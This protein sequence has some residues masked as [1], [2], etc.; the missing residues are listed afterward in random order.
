M[1]PADKEILSD[2][3]R[4][5]RSVNLEAKRVEREFGVSIPQYLCLQHLNEQA[6]FTASMKEIKDVL[7]LNA[8]TATGIVQRLERGG[9]VAKLPK[10]DDKRKSL[11][12]LTE[13]GAEVV[14]RNPQILHERLLERLQELGPEDY[15]N[16]RSAFRV[17]IEFL[18]IERID[19]A[20][21][22]TSE[23][24]LPNDSGQRV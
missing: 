2:L 22:V 16:L 18:E 11:I 14:K 17:I 13:R 15:A 4:I 8:S 9:Y 23:A 6:E 1:K 24:M 20:P 10:R 12:V 7:Q 5:I 3:R 21:I 19:A